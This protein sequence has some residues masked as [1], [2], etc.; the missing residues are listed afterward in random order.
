MERTMGIFLILAGA[1]SWMIGALV[2][3]TATAIPQQL[4]AGEFG[5]VGAVLIAGGGVVNAIDTLRNR[6]YPDKRVIPGPGGL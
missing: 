4:L 5:I 6:M 2:L 1:I 3:V